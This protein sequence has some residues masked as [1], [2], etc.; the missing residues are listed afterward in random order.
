MVWTEIPPWLYQNDL[1]D[2]ELQ[3]WYV[4]EARKKVRQLAAQLEALD[5][6]R[7]D[8]A[9]ALAEA[10]V[11]VRDAEEALGRY[12]HPRAR[13]SADRKALPKP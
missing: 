2:G 13:I 8:V 3:A 9:R 6:E 12:R 10:L 7:E 1:P 4:R 11:F 5:A